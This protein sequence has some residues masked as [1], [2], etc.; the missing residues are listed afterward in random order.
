MPKSRKDLR[1]LYKN[2]ALIQEAAILEILVKT[3][4]GSPT[5][6]PGH[7]SDSPKS[8]TGFRAERKCDRIADLIDAM[9]S[10][11]MKYIANLLR[12]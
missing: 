6:S 5:K 9:N 12:R 1:G 4:E 3:S 11:L 8:R 7:N 10:A 2:R